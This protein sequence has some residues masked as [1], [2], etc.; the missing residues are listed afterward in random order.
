[1]GV[2]LKCS[3]ERTRGKELLR[4][5]VTLGFQERF[6]DPEL[7]FLL[8]E[9]PGDGW[10]TRAGA[11]TSQ[12]PP[13]FWSWHR[14]F[15]KDRLHT[16]E[17]RE[18]ARINKSCPLN[19]FTTL[20]AFTAILGGVPVGLVDGERG[21]LKEVWGTGWRTDRFK[22]SWDLWFLEPLVVKKKRRVSLGVNNIIIVLITTTTYCFS[23]HSE[24]RT[25]SDLYFCHLVCRGS[26][27]QVCFWELCQKR[28]LCRHEQEL[29]LSTK[30]WLQKDSV[31][32]RTG[33]SRVSMETKIKKKK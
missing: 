21:L 2:S 5:N 23:S 27:A 9:G 8:Q 25:E 18:G 11:Q 1:M 10:L 14:D 33:Y 20:Q 22:R 15:A 26:S 3:P 13:T 30:F 32:G 4:G 12:A 17:P 6:K 28:S 7:S 16:A 19:K 29:L 31:L 24:C